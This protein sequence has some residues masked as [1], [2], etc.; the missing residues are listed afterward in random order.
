MK[1]SSLV[2]LLLATGVAGA[3]DMPLSEILRPG[4][5][6][7]THA[8]GMPTQ[9]AGPRQIDLKGRPLVVF[10]LGPDGMPGD[11]RHEF[12]EPT[13][14]ISV[15]GGSAFLIADAADRYIWAMRR[16]KDGSLD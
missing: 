1:R 8:E 12:K 13:V 15:L 3:Q 16:E 9:T 5:T 2:V 6:W 11:V 14:G 4:E 7:Q 10:G